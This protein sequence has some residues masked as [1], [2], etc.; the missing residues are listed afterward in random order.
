MED[1]IFL[2]SKEEVSTVDYGFFDDEARIK[3]TT[4]FAASS[5][6]NPNNADY[7]WLRSGPGNVNFQADIVDFNGTI[8]S[9]SVETDDNFSDN[10]WGGIVPALCIN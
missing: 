1:K 10:Y 2:L 8:T 9:Q 3:Q 4:D 6:P 7:W 5:D